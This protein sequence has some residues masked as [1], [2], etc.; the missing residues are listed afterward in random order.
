MRLKNKDIAKKLGI[1]TTAVSLAINNRPGVS[2][3]TRR[4]VLKLINENASKSYQTINH[5]KKSNGSFL[6]SMHKKHG[7]VIIDKPFFSDLV[8]TIQQEAM[9]QSYMLTLTHYMPG[10]N[11]QQ[12]IEYIMSLPIDGMILMATE[13][14]YDDLSYYRQIDI[15]IVL[16]DSSFDLARVDSMTLDNQ[17]SILRAFDYAYE[18]GHRD[19]GYLK[20]SVFINNFGHRYDGFMK[21]IREYHLEQNHHP[22][23]TLPCS[24][25]TAYKKMKEFLKSRPADFV[26]PTLFLADLDYIALG[27]MQAL[28]EEGFRIPEDISVIGFDDVSACE[29]FEPQLTTIRVNRM[30][31][32]RLAVDRLIEKIKQPGDY[33]TSTQV[34]SD[35]IIRKS[36][37]DIGKQVI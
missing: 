26:M 14:D 4:N 12:Y 29:V 21:G 9:K 34:S 8:E 18:L 11:I 33:Y 17:T 24:I 27:A 2:E 16:L 13:M 20:S 6:L 5:E 36:V 30:D 19:I 10:Q 25:E 32:G 22:V 23:I 15:P 3:E 31:I 7:E 37:K 1:S 28:K 35:L